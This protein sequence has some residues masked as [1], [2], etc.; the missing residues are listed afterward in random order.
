MLRF[1]IW[2]IFVYIA[3]KIIG[4]LVRT[5]RLLLTPNRDVLNRNARPTV[6]GKKDIED[7]PYEEIK[8]K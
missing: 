3:A 7:I 4:Q 6:R 5:V 1:I 2:M 8:D